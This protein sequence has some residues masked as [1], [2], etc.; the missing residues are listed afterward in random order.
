MMRA[1]TPCPGSRLSR[2]EILQ[3]GGAGLLGLGLPRLLRAG[4]RRATRA[5]SCILIFL[6]GGP[7]HLDMW[8]MKP[9]APKEVRGEFQPIATSLPGVQFSEHLPKLARHMHRCTLVR[10]VHH[11]VNNAHAAAVYTGLTGHDRGEIGGGAKPTDHPALGSVMGLCRPPSKPVVPYV[12][13]PYITQE[14][15]GGPP[16]PG[17]FGGLLG[18]TRDPLFVLRNPDAADFAM[19]E[20]GLGADMSAGRLDARRRLLDRL[21]GGVHDRSAQEMSGFQG[22]AFDLLVSAAT[23]KAFRLDQEPLAVRDRYG[24]NI[25]GQSVLLARRLIE[26]GTRVAC[27]SWAPDANATWDTHG[28]NFVN[29]K[30]KLLPQFDAAASSLLTDL[31]ERGLLER[32]VV[33]MMGEFGRSPKINGNAGRDH[34]NFCYSLLL[35]GGGFKGGFVYGASDRIGARPSRNPVTPGDIIATLYTCLDID[36]NLELTDRLGRPFALVPWGTTIHELRA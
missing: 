26:A 2:R 34:W 27:I 20:L 35:A 31:A 5:D 32:T 21:H 24:R 3:V 4:E 19:P 7:S 14:G 30:T 15:A 17:F 9:D 13:M 1:A 23:Q 6:N 12:S 10:S 25:Y 22:K 16:Q 11:S 36:P 33:A 29:L 18:R 28:N 8:D